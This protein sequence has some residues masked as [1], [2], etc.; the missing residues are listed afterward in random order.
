MPNLV[1]FV[2]RSHLLGHIGP[3]TLLC[4]L[5][6]SFLPT[7]F[8]L[9]SIR[10]LIRILR[11]GFG[12]EGILLRAMWCGLHSWLFQLVRVGLAI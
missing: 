10:G 9:G 8:E 5:R 4:G 6:R 11:R 7:V 2:A 12:T 1:F 3:S